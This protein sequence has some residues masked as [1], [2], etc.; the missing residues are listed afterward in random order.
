MAERHHEQ[1]T[2]ME[3]LADRLSFYLHTGGALSHEKREALLA[4]LKASDLSKHVPTVP[5][6]IDPQIAPPPSERPRVELRQRVF[7]EMKEFMESTRGRPEYKTIL[8]RDEHATA[9]RISIGYIDEYL[10]RLPIERLSKAVDFVCDFHTYP[11]YG[12]QSFEDPHPEIKYF[13]DR[14]RDELLR[15]DPKE[16]E[17][18]YY[19][20]LV[21]DLGTSQSSKSDRAMDFEL[22]EGQA[23]NLRR[24]LPKLKDRLRRAF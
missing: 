7:N 20:R 18:K 8:T 2:E 6:P 12:A 21:H 16:E 19:Y 23:K 3:L 22:S 5:K 1:R 11:F 10:N 15:R 14:L 17:M 13:R 4:A 24:H 9:K